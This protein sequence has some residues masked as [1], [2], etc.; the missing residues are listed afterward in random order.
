ME[1]MYNMNETRFSI[2]VISRSY[3]IVNKKSKKRY[4]A[5]SD[6]QK[7]ISVMKYIYMNE[8]SIISFIIFKKE[9]MLSS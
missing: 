9:K 8:E 5:Q 3:M 2:G 7:W 4:Q 1:D 6:R